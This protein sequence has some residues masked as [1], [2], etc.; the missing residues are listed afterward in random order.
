ML[1]HIPKEMTPDLMKI[2][3]EMGHCDE[4]VSSSRWIRGWKSL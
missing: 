1:K 2:L 3:M 4:L